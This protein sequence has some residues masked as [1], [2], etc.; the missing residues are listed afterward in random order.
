MDDTMNM[1]NTTQE[2][3]YW[4]AEVAERL[5]TNTST[6]RNWT[7]ALEK[8]G[9]QFI[10]D[11]NG[12][13][14]FLEKDIENLKLLQKCLKNNMSMKDAVHAVI[15][16]VEGQIRTGVVRE[17]DRPLIRPLSADA[18]GEIVSEALEIKQ[19]EFEEK[20]EKQNKDF[21]RMLNQ[22]LTE[23]AEFI[24]KNINEITEKRDRT[25]LEVEVKKI[26]ETKKNGFQKLLGFF[27]S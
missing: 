8:E 16:S 10:K 14:A 12:R 23:Q 21:E 18:V 7:N 19:K 13:R 22:K 11:A 2:K 15:S 26:E 17:K 1:D 6:L 24:L 3:A 27:K 4:A 25:A 9:Y 20:I 5:K